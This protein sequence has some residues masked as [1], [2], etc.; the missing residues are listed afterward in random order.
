MLLKCVFFAFL[1]FFYYFRMT[2]YCM[3]TFRFPLLLPTMAI[4]TGGFFTAFNSFDSIN[5]LLITAVFLLLI[6]LTYRFSSLFEHGL[7]RLL[8]AMVLFFIL[9]C[10]FFEFAD[11]RKRPENKLFQHENAVFSGVVYEVRSEKEQSQQFIVQ[12]DHLIVG[13]NSTPTNAKILVNLYEASYHVD[14]KLLFNGTILPIKNKGNPGEFDA[15]YYYQYKGIVGTIALSNHECVKIGETQSLNGFF[16]RWRNALSQSME[17][18]LDGVFLGV[19]KALL[20]GDKADLDQET[21]RIFSNTGSMHVLAVSGLHVGLLLMM[22]QKVLLLFARWISKRQALLLS[23]I[24]VWVYGFLSGA[25]PSVMRAV[26][27]FTILAY[28]QL[29]YRKTAAVN[30]L[31]LSA[32]ILFVWDPWV[33]FD[34]GFQLSYGAMFGIFLLYQPLVDLLRVDQKLVRMIWEGTMVGIAA[35]I[36]T[37]PLTLYWFYQFPNYFALANLGVMLFGFLV[38]LLGMIYLITVYIPVISVVVALVFSFT[39]IGLVWWVGI[40]DQLPGAVSGGFHFDTSVLIIAYLLIISWLMTIYKFKRMR[41]LLVPVSVLCIVLVSVQRY[42]YLTENELIVFKAKRLICAIKTPVGVLG[43]YDPKKGLADK[44]PRELISF[45]QY[46]GRKIKTLALTNDSLAAQL[47]KTKISVA[48]ATNGWHIYI[49]EKRFYYQQYG[50]PS[51]KQNPKLLA[52]Y[53]QEYLNPTNKWG[54]FVLAY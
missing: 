39:I 37:T 50:I 27:M 14:D 20:L 6:M 8:I 31:C 26:V 21:M 32:V 12:L 46:S 25:S 22:F 51:N 54:A 38:L 53:L 7:N 45:Q 5:L 34:I 44:V 42:N 33:I 35:T 13:E 4:F 36:F 2:N 47:G 40:I 30:S 52:S 15:R 10:L 11:F 49:N 17:Q 29:F 9:G 3:I 24:L 1:Y 23:L 43:F 48:K 16:T 41:F 18:H 19:A 28:G